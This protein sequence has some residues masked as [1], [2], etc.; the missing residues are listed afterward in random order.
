ME[1]AVVV[2]V[3]P[4]GDQLRTAVVER[5]IAQAMALKDWINC[6]DPE[7]RI[8]R[9]FITNTGRAA[10]RRL[11]AED[12]NRE[13]HKSP[14]SRKKTRSG[15]EGR[16]CGRVV[17]NEKD[18]RETR[19]QSAKKAQRPDARKDEPGQKPAEVWCA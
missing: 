11:T 7:G 2:R 19:K 8:A 6:P 10:L 4:E 1:T 14:S 17:Q 13:T 3:T 15:R 18:P 9:Y 12:E 16:D 5:E